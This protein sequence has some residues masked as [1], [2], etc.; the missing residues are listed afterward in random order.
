MA[1]VAPSC[2]RELLLMLCVSVLESIQDEKKA[3]RDTSVGMEGTIK[4]NWLVTQ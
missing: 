3:L 4:H 1:L 2:V